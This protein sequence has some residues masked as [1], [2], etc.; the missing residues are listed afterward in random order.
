M[1]TAEDPMLASGDFGRSF[2]G[3]DPVR[4]AGVGVF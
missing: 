4:N 3:T 1:K 2:R